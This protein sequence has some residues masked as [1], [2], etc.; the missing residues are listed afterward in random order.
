MKRPAIHQLRRFVLVF[1]LLLAAAHLSPISADSGGT[2]ELRVW[3]DTEDPLAIFVSARTEGDQPARLATTRLELDDGVGRDSTY[4]YGDLSFAGFVIRVWQEIADPSRIEVSARRSSGGWPESGPIAVTLDQELDCCPY[5]YGD[6]SIAPPPETPLIAVSPGGDEVP[7]LAALTFDFAVPPSSTDPDQLVSIDPAAD[8]S[9]AWLD[10]RTLLFQPDYPGWALGQSYRVTVAAAQA[11]LLEDYVHTFTAEGQLRVTYVIPGP[12]D[13]ETPTNAQILVQ[14]NRSVTSL[15]VLDEAPIA[16]LL[17]ITPALEGQGEWLNTSLYRF[18]PTEFQP[19]TRYNVRIPAALT[20]DAHGALAGDY[21][22]SFTTV[23]PAVATITPHDRAFGVLPFDPIVVEFTQ[24]MDRE[25]VEAGLIVRVQEG[26]PVGGTFQWNDESTTVSFTPE[27]QLEL[28]T[29]YEVVVPAGLQG[30]GAG[31]SRRERQVGF[32]TIEPLGVDQDISTAAY[33]P[34]HVSAFWLRYNRA[35]DAES[36]KSRLTIID[37]NGEPVTFSE[38]DD[39]GS[40]VRVHARLD[41]SATYTIRIAEGVRDQHGFTA[42]AYETEFRTDAYE[43]PEPPRIPRRLSLAVPGSFTTLSASGEQ[44]LY[45]HAQGLNSVSFSLYPLTATESRSLLGRGYVDPRDWWRYEDSA[46]WPESEPLREWVKAIDQESLKA[47][48]RY[49]T[50]LSGDEPLPRGH[51]MLIASST[52]PTED[53]DGVYR[54]KLVVSVVDAAVITKQAHDELLVWAVDHDSGEPLIEASV[55][56]EDIAVNGSQVVLRDQQRAETDSFGL[57]ST[58]NPGSYIV[59]VTGD[60]QRFGV[61]SLGHLGWWRRYDAPQVRAQVYTERSIYR[62]GETVFFKGIVRHDSDAEYLLLPAE[63]ELNLHIRDSSY[64]TIL[65]TTVKSN[66][67]G[68]FSGQFELPPDATTGWYR[69]GVSVTSGCCSAQSNFLVSQFRVP[70]FAVDLRAPASDYIA[71]ETMRLPMSADYFFGTPVADVEFTWDVRAQPSYM[72]VPGLW[73]YSFWDRRH[74]WSAPEDWRVHRGSGEGRTDQNGYA[75]LEQLANLQPGEGTARFTISAIVTDPSGQSIADS[76]S[77]TVHPARYYA[78]L[79]IDSYLAEVDE[80][81]QIDLVTI[82]YLGNIA[83]ERAVTVRM[84]RERWNRETRKYVGVETDVQSATTNADGEAMIAFTPALSG[85]YRL[86]AESMDE[87]GRVARSSRYLWVTGRDRE[88]WPTLANNV[89]QLIADRDSYEIGDVARV[90]VPAPFAGATGLVTLERGTIHSTEVRRFETGSEVLEIPIEDGHIPNIYV[91]VVLYR[92]PTDADP[93][94]RFHVGYVNLSVS[95]EPRRLNVSITPDRNQASPGETVDYRV[96]V[97]DAEGRGVASELSVAIVDQAVHSLV[98]ADPPDFMSSF[99]SERRLGV[100][101]ASSVTISLDRRNEL[102]AGSVDGLLA[103]GEGDPLK[104]PY[105]RYDE[106]QLH[107]EAEED[108]MMEDGMTDGDVEVASAGDDDFDPSGEPRSDF[109][110]TA[111]WLG[112]LQTNE[113]GEARFE[114]SLP[115]NVTT[116]LATAHAATT[117]TQVGSGESELLVTKPLLVR[118]AL[119]RFVRV[120]DELSLRTL[121]TNRTAR[122]QSVTVSIRV[123]GGVELEHRTPESTT[124][125]AGGT[126]EFSWPAAALEP[127]SATVTFSAVGSSDLSDAVAITIPSQL[128]ITAEA[129]ATGGVVE[130]A[131]VVEALYL[132][133]YLIPGTGSL[134]LRLQASLVGLLKG[135]L[136]LFISRQSRNE[137][138]VTIASRIIATIA[139]QR[140]SGVGFSEDHS[141][142]IRWDVRQLIARQRSGGWSWCQPCTRVNH[143]VSAWVLVALGEAQAAGFD[144]PAYSFRRALGWIDEYLTRETDAEKPP[145]PNHHAYLHYAMVSALYYGDELD[146]R[147]AAD[148]RRRGEAIRL[149]AVEHRSE[150]TAW[151]RAYLLLGLLKTGHDVEH[152]T[153]RSLLNDLSATAI[154]SANGNH[155]QDPTLRGSMHNGSVRATA[156]VL[157][158][159]TEA[160]P[161]H[162]LIE[163]TVRWLVVGRSQDRWKSS[164]ERAQGMA[165]LGAYSRLTGEHEGVY[166]YQALLGLSRLLTGRFDVEAGALSDEIVTP[167]DDLPLGEISRLQLQRESG[168]PGR[169]YYALNL[170]YVTPASRIEALNRGLAVSRRYSLVDE[171]DRFVNSAS[172]GD[173]VRV[174]VTVVAPT[175][176]LF[177]RVEDFLPAGLEPVDPRLDTVSHWTRE[178][179]QEEREQ[180]RL[181]GG[182]SYAAPWFRWYFNPWDQVDTR[183]DRV[184]LLADR[185]PEGVYRFVYF[186]RATTPGQFVAPPARAEETFFP[187]VFGRGDSDR[188][189]VHSAE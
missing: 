71:G 152:E 91:V 107:E 67:V 85:R 48:R 59:H 3:Q 138:T 101:T 102:F 163:E 151:G 69:L 145:D 7:R 180:S 65:Q 123:S 62:A 72:Y 110:N 178:R 68:S 27:P 96:R 45:F 104:S 8:G 56:V 38:V 117:A 186:A 139:A 6:V 112:H 16:P 137:S 161:R 54:L 189:I 51:Y 159:L 167:L 176:R 100:L 84:I 122:P 83:A 98:R 168:T 60:D 187:E 25:S 10:E 20:A 179:L 64:N 12:E 19:N 94:P 5:R 30:Q 90:L 97:T 142:Q 156:L 172:I 140:A 128:N 92:P 78:G 13:I 170:R 188:F 121:V 157:L 76:R 175:D 120:G 162:P 73:R 17:E 26:E 113:R 182:P 22:W 146:E 136:Y 171:P 165:A 66:E 155:W 127:G 154:P 141:A 21:E 144:V 47:S 166:D 18:I 134:E 109:R 103:S 106:E 99:W 81:T 61:L 79:A 24:P 169:M 131:A 132:P 86:V 40:S 77:V 174:E 177:V 185:L 164:V 52:F 46:F 150:L 135:E 75:R 4:R 32:R 93:Y 111:L 37:A 14:F 119:P 129:V 108:A 114:L 36:V 80:P 181:E 105:W 160:A 126:A 35:V 15:T 34:S 124:I 31:G 57:A 147:E 158:A 143:W 70:E 1:A 28:L 74:Y 43:P 95:A 173:L 33:T 153:V 130:D 53:G 49:S 88:T 39:F 183:D 118:P 23:A 55:L 149:L 41:H 42:E 148:Q 2:V 82:D 87:Q 115:D 125:E 63:T 133:A 50:L 116:W 89:I 58:A 44:R 29:E 184:I 9:F 11:G